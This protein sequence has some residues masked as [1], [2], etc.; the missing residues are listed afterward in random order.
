MCLNFQNHLSKQAQYETLMRVQ[1]LEFD[2]YLTSHQDILYPKRLVER[3]INC[4]KNSE[5]KKFHFYQYPQPPYAKGRIY[6]DSL[7]EEPIALIIS[8]EE[9]E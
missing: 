3:M 4:I 9:K 6:L 8:E 2:F 1:S 5:G 7:G